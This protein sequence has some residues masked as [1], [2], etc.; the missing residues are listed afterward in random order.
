MNNQRLKQIEEIFSAAIELPIDKRESFFKETCGADEDLRREIESL[1]VFE[2]AAESFLDHPPETLAAEMF[3]AED[4]KNDFIAS[5]I[6]YYKVRQLLG[7]GGMGEVY[8]AEDTRLNRRVALKFLSLSIWSNE[9]NLRRFKQEA[10]AASALNYPN[11][12]TI[13]EFE[14][15]SDVCYLVAEFVEGE[16]L[17]EMLNR[18]KFS[19]KDALNIA[20][21]IAVPLAAAH[22]ANIVHRDIKPE[23]IMIREDGFVKILDFGLAKLTGQTELANDFETRKIALTKTGAIMGTTSY[24]SPEQVRGK[25]NIDA[26]TDIWSFGV[27]LF[28][29][30]S[31]K[32]PFTGETS[33][34]II[35]SILKTDAPSLTESFADCPPELAQIVEKSLTKDVEDRYPQM[36]DLVKE[37][38]NLKNRL[39]FEAELERSNPAKIANKNNQ[40]QILAVADNETQRFP[41]RVTA[42]G[43]KGSPRD[44]E[45]VYQS[46]EPKKSST[47]LV[48]AIGL[49]LVV[50]TIGRVFVWSAIKANS[51]TPQNSTKPA[52]ILTNTLDEKTALQIDYSLTVQSYNDGRYKNPFKLSGEMLFGNKDRVRLNIESP[53][54][55]F[56]YILNESPKDAEGKTTFNILFPSPTTNGG[57]SS[58]S[59]AQ[60]IQIPEN[61]WFE[62][63]DKEGT[64]LVWLVWSPDQIAEL[65]SARRFANLS[66]RGKIKDAALGDFIQTLLRKYQANRKNVNRDNEKRMSQITSNKDILTH[67]N[68]LWC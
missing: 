15:A 4:E 6:G 45:K 36:R 56:L 57:N 55:G 60:E 59:A 52:P 35:A 48:T 47:I 25:T 40:A 61:S 42:S 17:R 19:I 1:L 10:F 29:M 33:G 16:T 7:K 26:R 27:V 62:L 39:E 49:I 5:Q 8:L 2:S 63:D 65:E 43:A 54:N 58:L 68:N 38:K 12:L 50:A 37:L 46:G 32:V 13:Y 53:Q 24:M 41:V 66:D 18:A 31:G 28:E 22:K 34:D 20:E 30:L 51:E 11:I 23:N 3:A 14:A 9:N 21:Q 67:V 64:E 44:S